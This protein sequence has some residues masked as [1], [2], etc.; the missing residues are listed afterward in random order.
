MHQVPILA[1]LPVADVRKVR[2]CTLST[3]EGCCITPHIGAPGMSLADITRF[4]GIEELETDP[5]GKVPAQLS[6][7]IGGKRRQ[8]TPTAAE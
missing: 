6:G 1:R 7:K 4:N 5:T 3:H 8:D 2:P